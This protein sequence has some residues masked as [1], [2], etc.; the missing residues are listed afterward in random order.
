M[1]TEHKLIF[2]THRETSRTE[3]F[4]KFQA[5]T[6]R[7]PYIRISNAKDLR[8]RLKTDLTLG[9]FSISTLGRF[10]GR[11]GV[12]ILVGAGDVAAE[13]DTVSE[14][15]TTQQQSREWQNRGIHGSNPAI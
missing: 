9:G 15:E 11:D 10:S 14:C 12:P 3:N 2:V 8:I 1:I 13:E 4:L 7:R 5:K 6:L